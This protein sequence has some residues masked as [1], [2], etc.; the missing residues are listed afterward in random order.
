MRIATSL[1]L[2][3]VVGIGADVITAR[4]LSWFCSCSEHD[5]IAESALFSESSSVFALRLCDTDSLLD[6]FELKCL[7]SSVLADQRI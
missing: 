7:L 2:T 5:T 6:I 3:Y 4:S 1:R